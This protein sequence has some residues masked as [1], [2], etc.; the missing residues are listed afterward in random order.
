L[1]EISCDEVLVEV[2]HFLHGELDSTR[3]ASLADHLADC[4]TCMD[5]AEFARRL[6]DIVRTKCRSQP[7]EYLVVRIQTALRREAGE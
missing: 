6:K 2:E 7:P 5:H 3:A 1:S 4:G